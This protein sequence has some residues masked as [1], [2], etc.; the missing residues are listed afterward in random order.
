M[1]INFSSAL[2]VLKKEAVDPA[3]NLITAQ[4]IGRS[5]FKT[6]AIAKNLSI[7]S[8]DDIVNNTV[9]FWHEQNNAAK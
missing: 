5:N 4:K 6:G 8:F 3:Q 1:A 9:A 7:V 2:D